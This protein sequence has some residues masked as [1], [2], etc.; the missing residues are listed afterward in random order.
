MVSRDMPAPANSIDGRNE[1]TRFRIH[2]AK[3]DDLRWIGHRDLVRLMERLFR[4]LGLSLAMSQGFH[5]KPKTRFASALA[6]GIE[7]WN[8]WVEVTL[9]EPL[10]ELRFLNMLRSDETPGLVFHRVE[11]VSGKMPQVCRATYEIDPPASSRSGLSAAVATLLARKSILVH[12]HGRSDSVDIRPGIESITFDGKRLRFTLAAG[13]HGAVR[14][15]EVLALLEGQSWESEGGVLCRTRLGFVVGPEP[16]EVREETGQ[17]AADRSNSS[18][19][20]PSDA[21]SDAPESPGDQIQPQVLE[22]LNENG[23]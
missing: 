22:S 9:T 12:R 1:A 10:D 19:K 15:R 6:L 14:P 20:S 2:F 17:A 3:R 18:R 5:P 8:E 7:G 4:R 11:V 23:L 21:E 13:R 16:A